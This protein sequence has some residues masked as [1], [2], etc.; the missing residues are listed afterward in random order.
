MNKRN[1]PALP[2]AQPRAGITFDLPQ[3]A[4]ARWN[5][6]IQ[7]AAKDEASISIFD[8]IGFDPW[9][10]DGVTAKRIAAIL[11][12][13][14]GA[15][16]AVNINSPGGDMFEGLAI[17][18]LLREYKGT[19]TVNVMGVAASAAS[20]IAMAGDTIQI[21]RSA[22]LMIH[23]CWIM[24]IG[25]KTELR[26]AAD[27]IEPFD[28]AMADV[29]AA[30]TGLDFK[31]V[32]ELMD[33][34]TFIAGS[35][36]VE[37]G[38]ADALLPADQITEKTGG[39]TTAARALDTALAKSGMPRSERRRLLN[40]IKGTPSATHDGTPSA[41]AAADLAAP[42]AALLGALALLESA[43]SK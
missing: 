24:A 40:E 5:P 37:Q 28:R 20:I 8:P 17:Y 9:T 1:L 42:T 34:E 26:A 15:D 14:D 7:A 33:A 4:L 23:N 19:V 43:A 29:Y 2:A 41:A 22:F 21:G 13:L 12:N 35:D 32:A 39:N 31:A 36:A 6:A 11:R 10:G 27:T 38:F 3:A 16:V 30:R 25:N 18:N